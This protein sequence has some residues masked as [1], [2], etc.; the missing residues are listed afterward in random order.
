[1]SEEKYSVGGTFSYDPGFFPRRYEKDMARLI[2]RLIENNTEGIADVIKAAI[3]G[4]MEV[5]N[6]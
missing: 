4:K 3:G 2:I 6:E 5:K 1:M